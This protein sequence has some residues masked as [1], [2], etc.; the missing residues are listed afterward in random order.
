MPGTLWWMT[1]RRFTSTCVVSSG[2][3]LPALYRL[4]LPLSSKTPRDPCTS[5]PNT[6]LV[7]CARKPY[8]VADDPRPPLILYRYRFSVTSPVPDLPEITYITGISI[9]TTSSV[10]GDQHTIVIQVNDPHNL[11]SACPV[12]VAPCLAEGALSVKFDGEEA[13][14]APGVV[15]LAPDVAVS[16]VNL[17]GACRYVCIN[18]DRN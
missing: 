15:W 18:H 4:R 11:D 16:A 2:S 9:T 8:V 17:P 5:H 7:S 10:D 1:V 14:L 12:G 3:S 13:L 6:L